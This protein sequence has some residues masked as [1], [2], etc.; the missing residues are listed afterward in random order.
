M[1]I[2]NIAYIITITSLGMVFCSIVILSLTVLIAL[3]AFPPYP[4]INP[5]HIL[6]LSYY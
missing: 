3:E 6:P 1:N 5:F 2:M 4:Y